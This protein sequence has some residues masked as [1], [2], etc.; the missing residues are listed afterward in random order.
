MTAEDNLQIAVAKYLD[1]Q[2]FT[3]FHCPNEGKRHPVAGKIAKDEGLKAGVP[4][5]MIF[6]PHGEY[7]GLAIELKI[8]KNNQTDTQKEWQIKLIN[9]GW[10]YE[11][12]RSLEEV[13]QLI[14]RT[15]Y[16]KTTKTKA[17]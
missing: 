5:C 17:A 10:Q 15:Y 9:C 7:K 4:D 11:V 3:W 8:G 14:E 2:R 1:L 12:C 6:E 16:E 13:I